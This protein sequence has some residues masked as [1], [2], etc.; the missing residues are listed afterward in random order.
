ML[1]KGQS[2]KRER[3]RDLSF[4]W[5]LFKLYL[6]I[7]WLN[8]NYMF[9]LYTVK[10]ALS[11]SFFKHNYLFFYMFSNVHHEV[12]IHCLWCKFYTEESLLLNN[13]TL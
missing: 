10:K 12:Y 8:I 2:G 11:K 4:N 7:I 9:D 1:K 13:D 5:F 3:V 6:V